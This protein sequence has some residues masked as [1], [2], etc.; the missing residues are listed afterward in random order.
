MK[1]IFIAGVVVALFLMS[2]P[3]AYSFGGCEEDCAKCHSL[4][5]REAEEILSKMKATDA[6]VAGIKMSPVRGLWE[7]SLDRRGRQDTLYVGFSKKQV[8]RGTIIDIEAPGNSLATVVQEKKPADIRPQAPERY[9]EAGKIPLEDALVLGDIHAAKK[10]V[11]FTDPDCPYCSKLHAELRKVIEEDKDIVFY[12]KL[13]PLKIHPDSLWK[14]Q[15][16]LCNR[17]LTMLED[18]FNKRPIPKPSCQSPVVE[19]NVRLA[20]ELGITGT[21][22]LIM[23]DGFVLFGGRNARGIRNLIDSHPRKGAL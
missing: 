15:S 10:I 17:S 14:S 19:E 9:V 20:A 1:N 4:E 2:S 22:T 8:V 13:L 18:N 11:V 21:P 3:R 12:L 6:K 16:I 5:Q 7:V 23:P